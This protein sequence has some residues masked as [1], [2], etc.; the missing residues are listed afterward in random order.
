MAPS[1][2]RIPAVA[3]AA[4]A[5]RHKAQPRIP[6]LDG[7][8]AAA[9]LMVLALHLCYAWPLPLGWMPRIVALA[10]GHG[11]LGVDL[12][13]ILSG[14]LIT[15]ILLDSREKPHYFRNFYVRRVLR[16][17]PLY[18]TCIFVMSLFFHG[19]AKYFCLSLLFLANFSYY[20]HARVPQGPGTFWS[21]AVEEHFYLVWPFLVRKLKRAQLFALVLLL[22]LGSPILRAVCVHW[23]MDPEAQIYNYTF[24]RLDGLALG[25]L[26]AMWVRS[27]HYSRESAWKLAGLLVGSSLVITVAGWPYGIMATR[28]L[29]AAALRYTQAE[30][31]FA[32]IMALALAYRGSRATAILRS[33]I[34]KRIAD[35]SYALYLIHLSIGEAYYKLIGFHDVARYGPVGALLVRF[36]VVGTVAFGLAALSKK[37]LEDPFLR[38][39]RRFEA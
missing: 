4:P 39:K 28:S 9:I 3:V 31:V 10:I 24:F 29:L 18:F 13:F 34:A 38:L 5:P 25:A 2:A 17:I 12:F 22:V 36:V 6:E 15:G 14:F 37:F 35:W 26:L 11:W 20:F 33:R 8:R 19:A 7:F 27:R 21:L 23:G 16:I 30:F 1:P 32:G